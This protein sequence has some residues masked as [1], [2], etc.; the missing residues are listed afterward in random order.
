MLIAFPTLE[1]DFGATLAAVQWVGLS[2]LLVVSATIVAVGRAADIVGHKLVYTLGFVAFAIGSLLCG[3]APSLPALVG[4]RALQAV[5]AAMMQANSVAII[6]LAVPSQRL[7]R[8]LGI[9]G[10]AQALGL[11]LGPLLG[12]LLLGLGSWRLIFLVN[13]PIGLLG[14]TAAWFLIARVGHVPRR[15]VRFDWA[16]FAL[17]GPAVGALLLTVSLGA[18]RGWTSPSIL[19]LAAAAVVLGVAFAL[20]ERS[21]EAPMLDPGLFSRPAFS[22]GIVSGLLSYVALFGVLFAAPFHL[23]HELGLSPLRS[24]IVLTALPLAL[25]LVAPLAGRLSDRIGPR[26]LSVAGLAL[27]TAS[28]LLLAVWNRDVPVLAAE[29]GALGAGLGAFV[30]A[31]N[32]AVMATAPAGQAGVV[33]GALNLM[34]GIGTAVGLSLA[35]LVLGSVVGSRTAGG[36]AG[37]GFRATMLV[38]A[39]AAAVAAIVAALRRG[40]GL[41][42]ETRR[43]RLLP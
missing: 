20:R 16:G 10:A 6:T 1:R 3:L 38:L 37:Q 24:G 2:Y 34:R 26:V 41:A 36:L 22:V 32:A 19:A 5:G 9:Q 23:E 40:G 27:A 21:A 43:V 25:G 33:A 13:V 17:F 31:N 15:E 39:A 30:P 29:L 12:G 8:A 14:V 42:A 28:L 7:G 4:L 35:A 18:V 11:S